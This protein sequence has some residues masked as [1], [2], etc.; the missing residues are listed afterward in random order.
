MGMDE[1][2]RESLD[3][4]EHKHI[5]ARPK[6]EIHEYGGKKEKVCLCVLCMCKYVKNYYYH[7]WAIP[8]TATKCASNGP[9]GDNGL[10]CIYMDVL[11]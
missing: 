9:S 10:D 3:K 7:C 8:Q 4:L 11:T 2:G 6:S 5:I 1:G